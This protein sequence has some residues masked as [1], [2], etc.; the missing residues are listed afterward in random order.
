MFAALG[1]DPAQE[2]IYRVLAARVN[3]SVAELAADTGRAPGQIQGLL[4]ELAALGLVTGAEAA[5]VHDV[6]TVFTAAP[7]DIALGAV[8]RQRRDDL[9]AAELDLLSLA[10]QHHR[11]ARDRASGV[12]EVITDVAAVRHRFAQIQHSARHQVRSMMVPNLT[13]VPHEQ[14]EAGDAGLRRGVLYRAILQR[15]ALTEPGMIGDALASLSQGQQIRVADWVPV[16][17]VIADS[18]VAMVP[19]WSNRNTAAASILVHASGLLDALVALFESAWERAYPISANTLGDD[20]T[21][22]RPGEIDELD[23]RIL[24]LVLAGL[25]DQAA[26]GQL[27]I[28]RRTVQRRMT[29]LM[30]KAGVDTRIQLG[31]QAARRG[32]A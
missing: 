25:T 18:H 3:R 8:L 9:R 5:G 2:E 12:V 30:A 6:D 11:A 32:W 15:A 24:S 27:G 29:E 20:L 21:E 7:P 19:L 16:K 4:T 10:E 13:V 23:A 31:W 28:S 26:G 14:N 1:L 22:T 17:L